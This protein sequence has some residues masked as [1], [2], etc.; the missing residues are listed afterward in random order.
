[1]SKH[2]FEIFRLEDRVLFEA[3]AAAEIVDAAVEV[4]NDPNANTNAGDRAAQENQ[5]AVKNAPPEDPAAAILHGNVQN[6]DIDPADVDGAVNALIEGV[7]PAGEAE[8][9]VV[10]KSVQDI[11][12]ISSSL[13]ANQ[14]LL[15]LDSGNGLQ[16]LNDFLD[17]ADTQ[18]SAIHLLTHGKDGALHINGET[19][20]TGN[21][22][23]GTWSEIGEHLAGNGDIMIY[24]CETA[25]SS[26][27]VSLLQMIADASGCDVAASDDATGISGDWQLEHHLGRV[28]TSALNV[29]GYAYDLAPVTVTVDT[30]DDVV[31]DTDAFTSLREAI[32]EAAH[33]GGEYIINFANNISTIKL[34]ASRGALMFEVNYALEMTVDGDVD[35]DGIADVTISGEDSDSQIMNVF[36]FE[37]FTLNLQNLTLTS[38]SGAGLQGGA[39]AIDTFD[40][41]VTFN[42]DNVAITNSSAD[43]GGAVRIAGWNIDLEM[44]NST[45]Y[46]NSADVA[47]GALLLS[48]DNELNVDIVN[49]TITGNNSELDHSALDFKSNAASSVN[50]IN[51]IIAGNSDKDILLHSDTIELSMSHTIYDSVHD[52]AGEVTVTGTG[53]VQVTDVS[54]IFE[55]G[56][57][58]SDNRSVAIKND[59]VAAYGGTLVNAA[60]FSATTDSS[61]AILDD[62][63]GAA[64][65]KVLT[66]LGVAEFAIGAVA[67]KTT[68][69]KVTPVDRVVVYDGALHQAENFTCH[70]A[71]GTEVTALPAATVLSAASTATSSPDVGTYTVTTNS[72]VV[73]H[74]GSDV[75]DTYDFDWQSGKIEI[76]P[77]ELTVTAHN[78]QIRYGGTADLNNYTVTGWVSGDETALG[79]LV[80]ADPVYIAGYLATGNYVLAGSALQTP[81]NYTINYQPGILSVVGK[82]PSR[83]NEDMFGQGVQN[84]GYSGTMAALRSSIYA[85]NFGNSFTL[86]NDNP[87][88]MTYAG[89]VSHEINALGKVV[90]ADAGVLRISVDAMPRSEAISFD[91][92]IF[93]SYDG[94]TLP[95]IIVDELDIPDVMLGEELD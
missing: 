19:I 5:N 39:I 47:G 58:D 83:I 63:T 4:Q 45:I 41:D 48:A 3:A 23:A 91:D 37:D 13:N 22:D 18:F 42:M 79:E 49:S 54:T 78:Q 72:T 65:D 53:N 25:A 56:T 64:R 94:E 38:G 95:G 84:P 11:A 70:T 21:F 81:A 32:A 87:D 43:D 61:E 59:S 30:A 55:T 67:P 52:D 92:L 76:T 28:E 85:G 75:S 88:A 1:M 29:A 40:C 15:V 90:S 10:N 57:L 44:V 8:L 27:G 68:Y 89:L 60:D 62:Q 80:I 16:Q 71:G 36:L 24:G 2:D 17:T 74:N 50:V 86:G 33:N 77:K 9:V 93:D 46:G 14:Q 31:D 6:Q 73:M 20:D 7:I 82:M 34:D 35:A 26:Q 12:A 66:Q 51:S 69:L